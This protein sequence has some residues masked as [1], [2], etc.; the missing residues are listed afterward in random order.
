MIA[1][2]L[3]KE[4]KEAAKEEW[5][6]LLNSLKTSLAALKCTSALAVSA[7]VLEYAAQTGNQMFISIS[8]FHN[9]RDQV[10]SGLATLTNPELPMDQ[11]CSALSQVE[12]GHIPT[13]FKALKACTMR[14]S[15]SFEQAQKI[16]DYQSV[17]SEAAF[18]NRP[19]ML[20]AVHSWLSTGVFLRGITNCWSTL[21]CVLPS[22]LIIHSSVD[23]YSMPFSIGSS[24]SS[25][26]TKPMAVTWL[27]H[28]FGPP[29]KIL[30]LTSTRISLGQVTRV[31]QTYSNCGSS[32]GSQACNSLQR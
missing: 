7:Q 5:Q 15:R 14:L 8:K 32:A 1:A 13:Y 19:C 27:L 24:P 4:G 16:T 26:S 23:T 25:T 17:V 12:W 20:G 29:W 30:P 21:F 2:A 6:H 10:F 11:V 3:T 9:I 18:G 31:I 28:H 22:S